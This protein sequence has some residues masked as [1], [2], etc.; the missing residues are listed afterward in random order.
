MHHK[1]TLD[2]GLRI[3]TTTMP[4]TRSASFCFFIGVGSRYENEAVAGVSHFIEHLLFKGTKKR[5]TSGDI[6]SAI[7]GVGGILNAGTNKELTLYWTK[8]AKIH[9]PLSLDVITDI[10]LNSK[11]EPAEIERERQVVIEEINMSKDSP[12]SMVSLL[13]D[14][15]LWP[16]HSLGRDTA[17]TKESMAG[18]TRDAILKYL[19]TYYSPNNAV[20]SIAGN[21]K[22]QEAVDMVSEATAGWKR[23]KASPAFQPYR[24][25]PNPRIR[26]QNKDTEQ[27]HLCLGLP[28]LSMLDPRRFALDLLN[29]ILGE[30][31]SSRLFI[32]I[33]DKMGL[34]YNIYSSSDHFLDSGCLT[35]YAGVD[36]KK[37]TITLKAIMEQLSLIKELVPEEELSRA[38]EL[39]KG[40]LLLRMED[41]RDVAGWTGGQEILTGRI[42][43]MDQVTQKIDAVTAEEMKKLAQELLVGEQLRLAVVGPVKK[44]EPLEKLLKL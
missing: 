37:L 22:H 30:G 25:Q 31:M 27:A 11:F 26:I 33:R 13:I 17:G 38:K 6:C 29:V 8:T 28:G 42:L 44:E 14:E 3:V 10:L 40:R 12:A 24:P 39:A 7:E 1:T 2:N 19:R 18:I 15:L 9:F 23:K 36:P 21:I 43:T 4:H 32:E 5:P 16:G 35:V 20:V 41:T 34:A